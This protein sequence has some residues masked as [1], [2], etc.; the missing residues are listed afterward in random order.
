M[1]TYE[2]ECRKCGR[3]DRF[4]R[5]TAKPLKTCPRCGGAVK[6]LIGAGAG[7]IFKGHGFYATDYRSQGY[8]TAE[9]KEQAATRTETDAQNGTN[10]QP[11]NSA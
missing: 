7:I 10:L 8:R 1:P 9:Q 2:Y 6:R 4:Q 11:A 3:F 5:I